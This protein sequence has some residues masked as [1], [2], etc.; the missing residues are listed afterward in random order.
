M[1]EWIK[2]MPSKLPHDTPIATLGL[3]LGDFWSWAYS[4]LL[5]NRNR[6]VFAE[7][8]VARALDVTDAAR[9]EWDAT[10]LIYRG[11][12]IEVKS[13]AYV[14]SWSAQDVLS[15]IRFDI[16]KKRS[17]YA[18]TNTY[19]LEPIRASDCYVFCLFTEKD[20]SKANILDIDRWLFY[21]ASKEAIEEKFKD[22][23]TI[24]HPSRK[25]FK[26]PFPSCQFEAL[27]SLIDS[28]LGL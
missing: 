9:V 3:T 26:F 18:E 21:V 17:W 20:R 22:S 1:R 23:K 27:R 19:E 24:G 12:K 6:S 4:D 2:A 25:D 5:S 14:Q 16:G 11:K 15:Y 28:T 10:D 7:F 8:V 13:A